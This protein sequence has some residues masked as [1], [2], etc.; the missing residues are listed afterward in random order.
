MDEEK[1]GGKRIGAGRKPSGIEKKTISIYVPKGQIYK[2]GTEDK[3][4]EK[5]YDFIL[6]YG[7][8][9]SIQD[10]TK[11]TNEIKAHEQPKTNYEVN[12]PTKKEMPLLSSYD[13]WKDSILATRTVP[14]LELVMKQIKAE[15]LP[16]KIKQQL[17]AIAKDH[18]KN[19]YTD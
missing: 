5:L 18:S 7:Q 4:K 1:R 13:F 3:M 9:V 2:F 14:E 11:L 17:E 6:G 19:F 8:Q 12:I 15:V 16:L 10:L